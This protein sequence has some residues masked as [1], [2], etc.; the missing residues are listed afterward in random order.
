MRASVSSLL[1][2]TILIMPIP[3]SASNLE[4]MNTSAQDSVAI[5]SEDSF[6]I[7]GPTVHMVTNHSALIY[8]RTENDTDAAVYYG[9]NESL[10]ESETN[11]TLDTHHRVWLENLDID[12]KYY[13]QVESNGTLSEIYHFRTAPPDG[14]EFKIIVIGDNRPT[15]VSTEQPEEY[16]QIADLIIAEEPHLI[17]HSGD[18]VLDVGTDHEDNLAGWAAFN[19][20]TDR[21]GH[22][23]PIYG[24]L[25]NHDTGSKTGERRLEYF[26]DAFEQ[27]GEPQAYYS[28]D[29]A[30]VHF[31][32]ID[33]EE[34]GYE[35]R[36]VGDQ[37]TWL[38]NDLESSTS[39]MKFV[40]G[41]RPMYPLNHIGD[42]L[43]SVPAERLALQNLFEANNV[44]AY[45]CGH[46]HLYNRMTVNGMVHIISGG[47][48][49]PLYWTPWGGNFHHY[50]AANVSASEVDFAAIGLVGDVRDTYALPYEGPIE[51]FLRVMG[52]QTSKLIGTMPE[53]YFSETPAEYYYSWDSGTN[54][55]VLT[56]LPVTN[57]LHTLDVYARN[58]EDV[59]STAHY[60]FTA[61]G[62]PTPTTTTG[63]GTGGGLD[64]LII[65][66]GV[67]IA[68]VVV[69]LLLVWI[70][71]RS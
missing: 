59:W 71:K 20:V 68:G 67:A 12:S 57:G 38:V 48:G 33:T 2:L 7:R 5:P 1:L 26:F 65:F 23:A 4:R 52:N 43:D 36:I 35:G 31:T 69:V 29:Y 30:G 10:L 24:A 62:E 64:P 51:I 13:Y 40:M 70:R 18:F 28:F 63:T 6:F 37:L 11:S 60:V 58:D 15:S 56:G 55:T 14:G 34:F 32:I 8:W 41:H 47:A 49:A 21:M 50:V 19:N 66:G 17:L 16:K 42:S 9:L 54:Q 25:G 46:D 61:V 39:P 27:Y 45:V 53:I 44:T 22:Y 3:L